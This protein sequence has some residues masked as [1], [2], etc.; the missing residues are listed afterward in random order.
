P[1]GTITSA[2][3]A[4]V[5]RVDKAGP[6]ARVRT[7]DEIAEEARS[8]PRFRAELVAVFAGLALVLASVGVFAV[9]AF[10]VHERTRELGVRAALGARATHLVR[11]VAREVLGVALVGGVRGL[12][13]AAGLSRYLT[14]LLFGVTPLDPVTFIAAPLVLGLGAIVAAVVPAVRAARIAPAVALRQE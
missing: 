9:L 8:G 13:A 12:L 14:S 7:M 1:P 3:R 11:M 2:I 10:S 5:A 4:A 6:I